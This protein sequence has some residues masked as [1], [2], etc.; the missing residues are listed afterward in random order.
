MTVRALSQHRLGIKDSG[1]AAHSPLK[2]SSG[3]RSGE[4]K[5]SVREEAI[6]REE[7]ACEGREGGGRSEAV[8]VPRSFD[9]F[10]PQARLSQSPPL[11]TSQ[12]SWKGAESTGSGHDRAAQSHIVIHWHTPSVSLSCLLTIDTILIPASLD[13]LSSL[14]IDCSLWDS[15]VKTLQQPTFHYPLMR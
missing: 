13:G 4:K 5:M 9:P 14:Q 7:D 11:S 10:R 12:E 15:Q 2:R 6:W 1:L 8:F 3:L